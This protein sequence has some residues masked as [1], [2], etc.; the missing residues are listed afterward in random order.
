ML[1]QQEAA[2]EAAFVDHTSTRAT[3][4]VLTLT[5][6]GVLL[7]IL[8]ALVI[9]RSLTSPIKALVQTTKILTSGNLDVEPPLA[10]N[11]EIGRLTEAYDKMRLSLRSTITSLAQERR[12]TQSII[13]ASIDGVMLV[14]E[15]RTILKFNPAAER[16]SGWSASEAT[17][18]RCWEVFGCHGCTPKEAEEHDRICPLIQARAEND[19]PASLELHVHTQNGESRWLAVSCAPIASNDNEEAPQMVVGMHDITQLKAIEQLKSDF[20]AMVSHELRAPLTTVTGSVEM[21]GQMDPSADGESYH[22]VL[23]ILDQQT[24][25]LRQVVEE[26]LQLTRLDAGKL[27][28]NLQPIPVQAYLQSIIAQTNT[29]WAES[30]RSVILHPANLDALIWAD[31]S[32]LDIVFRNLFDNA[33]KYA[34]ADK[35]VEVKVEQDSAESLILIH[36]LDHGPGIPPD[37]IEHIFERF[38]RGTQSSYHWTRGYGLGLHIARALLNAHT[39][40]I[41]AS[42]YPLGACFTLSLRAVV[43]YPPPSRTLESET[44]AEGSPALIQADQQAVDEQYVHVSDIVQ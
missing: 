12:Q 36:V 42:N 16:L 8:L 19:D 26:V 40:Q 28:V 22:E 4:T 5:L 39:G 27:Q 32:L 25:R 20:V 10:R 31:P 17:G 23:G 33:R 30:G 34:F 35:A 14:D 6:L 44:L 37:Q 43:D 13:D 41:R 21:L 11:D 24:K 15:E 38:S 3:L 1:E 7:S 18:K 9:T 29:E 2:G